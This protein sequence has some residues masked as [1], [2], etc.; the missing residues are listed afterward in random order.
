MSE[1]E[2]P[3]LDAIEARVNRYRDASKHLY[4]TDFTAAQTKVRQ[5]AIEDLRDNATKDIPALLAY[6]RALEAERDT[7]WQRAHTAQELEAYATI[8]EAERAKERDALKAREREAVALLEEF[9]NGGVWH[10]TLKI[11]L[12][13]QYMGSDERLVDGYV[14]GVTVLHKVMGVDG[15]DHNIYKPTPMQESDVVSPVTRARAWLE[16]TK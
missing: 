6:A 9:V 10:P 8:R 1:N 5:E 12:P 2:R 4:F 7:W 15:E 13:V 3:D 16:G 11:G 14:I